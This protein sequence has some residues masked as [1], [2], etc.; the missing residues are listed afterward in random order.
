MHPAPALRIILW[1]VL[2]AGLLGTQPLRAWVEANADM[3]AEPAG[4]WDDMARQVGLGRFYSGLRAGSRA[5]EDRR[6]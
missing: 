4:R 1:A 3:L 5:V 6:F 2:A